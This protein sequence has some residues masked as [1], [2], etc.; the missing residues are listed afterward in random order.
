MSELPEPRRNADSLDVVEL[1]MAI[2]E[3]LDLD[4]S[5]SPAQRERLIRE[6]EA[7]IERGELGDL[8]D[9]DDGALGILV[10]K[11]GPKGPLG[12]AGA[13]AKPDES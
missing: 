6:I 12:Q 4:D 9:L 8:S 13:A 10:R 7:R 1:T 3:A 2:E 5:M 11:L